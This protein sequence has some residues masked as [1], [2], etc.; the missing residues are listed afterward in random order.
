MNN[1][2]VRRAIILVIL[3]VAALIGNEFAMRLLP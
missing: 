3:V 2:W 1:P